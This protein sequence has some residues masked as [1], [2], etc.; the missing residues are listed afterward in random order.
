VLP[1]YAALGS[2]FFIEEV[3][4]AK[5]FP[6]PAKVVKMPFFDPPRKKD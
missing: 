5:T 6:V 1:Q 3:I 4:E 2:R